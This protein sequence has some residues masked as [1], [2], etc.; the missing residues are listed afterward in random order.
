VFITLTVLYCLIALG[1]KAILQ[2]V[3]KNTLGKRVA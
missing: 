2:S 3:Y 1:L